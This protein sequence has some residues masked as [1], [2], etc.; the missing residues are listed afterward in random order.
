MSVALPKCPGLLLLSV[1][2]TIT[3]HPSLLSSKCVSVT[4]PKYPNLAY[5]S[6]YICSY[7][8]VSS[9]NSKCVCSYTKVSKPVSY[10]VC[11]LTKFPS[12][13]VISMPGNCTKVLKPMEARVS[14]TIPKCPSLLV[15]HA[16]VS[17]SIPKYPTL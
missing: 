6:I 9:I 15:V 7:T 10:C 8:K 3:K 11:N 16:G 5:H 1:S 17:V 4:I 13:S 14:V 2:I 12:R